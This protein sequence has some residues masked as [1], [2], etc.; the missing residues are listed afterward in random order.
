MRRL[1]ALLVPAL[2]LAPPA[3][4][5]LVPVGGRVV[6]GTWWEDGDQVVVNPY[7]STN[8]A[9]TFGVERHPKARVNLEKVRPSETPEEEY[10]RRAFA[11]R[12]GTA[13]DH[14]ALA[15][16]CEERKLKDLA[17]REWERVLEC[18]PA[19]E[20]ARKALGAAGLKEV[21]RRN[22]KA[23]PALGDLLQQYLG[24]E[25]PATRHVLLDRLK[26]EHD[27]ALPIAYLERARRS[28]RLPRGRTDDVP[29]TLRSKEV[30]GKRGVLYTMFVPPSYDPLRPT[31]LLVGL[32]GGGAGGKDGSEVTGSGPSAMNFYTQIAE[33]RG[34]LVACPSALRAPWS[35][36]E[37][38]PFLE[39]MMD[40]L[41]LLYNVDVNR[42]YLTG[43]S[44]GG[45]GSWYWGN[46]WAERWAAVGPM[47][48]GG[49]P[50]VDRFRDTQTPVYLFH[51]TDDNVCGVGPD[52]AA[53]EQMLKNGND[54]VY[55]ELNGVGHGCPPEVLQEMAA[56]FEVKRLAVGRGR[57]FRRSDA[58]RS[59]FLEK[60][61]ARLLKEEIAYLGDPE[62][63]DPRGVAVK[64][65][66]ERRRLLSEIDL[67]GGAAK[68]AAAKLAA[69]KDAEAVKPLAARLGAAGKAGDDVRAACAT[70][71]GG[72]GSSEA[73]PALQRALS[74]ESDAVFT[75]SVEALV[76]LGD[77][78]AGAS[79]LKAL[80]L[81]GRRFDDKRMG[82][83]M[84]YNDY[85]IRCAVLATTVRGVAA[86]SDPAA[87]AERIREQVV[88]RV[89]ETKILV[90]RLE[91]ADMIPE[92]VRA[93]LGVEVAKALGAL[94]D[95]AAAEPVIARL[96]AAFAGEA[97]VEAACD[98][99][100]RGPE[101]PTPAPTGG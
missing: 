73:L 6:K 13:D 74:D 98:E 77:R 55:T 94:A 82:S 50:G 10:C 42:V 12:A 101:A 8:R 99:A 29:L 41:F 48:G 14:A 72:I 35:A 24:A 38:E 47:A 66:E 7:N 83:G 70:A 84:S 17:A 46:E 96:R 27:A 9:M 69:T 53:A 40:E 93:S 18:D 76:T 87:A 32:H 65:E 64:P 97:S 85:E 49:C 59:S 52:R 21:L 31:P 11:S 78:A 62:P 34:W 3:L 63:P 75:A 71:L 54:F 39:A 22:G 5:D 58:I 28:G 56:F 60:H 15:R 16:W 67:G 19:H 23:N 81:Q 88:K 100:R 57:A 92:R 20:G 90:P 80:D 25:N 68:E 45:F 43:H 37:N 89:F 95:R 86:L 51:G 30:K 2:L 91:R 26:K 44:M 36:K 4:A 61:P 1:L 79:L 33:E